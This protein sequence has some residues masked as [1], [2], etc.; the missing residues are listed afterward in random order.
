MIL[1][2]KYFVAVSCKNR[3]FSVKVLEYKKMFGNVSCRGLRAGKL[4]ALWIS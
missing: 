2:L 1:A 3:S 4:P